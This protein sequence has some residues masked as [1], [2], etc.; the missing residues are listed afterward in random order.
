MWFQNCA[1]ALA[2]AALI[3]VVAP[4]RADSAHN[5]PIMIDHLASAISFTQLGQPTWKPTVQT[6]EQKRYTLAQDGRN[7]VY[8]KAYATFHAIGVQKTALS[9][10]E[11]SQS[12]AR[13]SRWPQMA[14]ACE[15]LL[16]NVDVDDF[17]DIGRLVNGAATCAN[18]ANNICHEEP[19]NGCESFGSIDQAF[20]IFISE[21][22]SAGFF[23]GKL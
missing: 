10:I 20:R 23:Q 18:Y 15:S 11:F 3:L 7:D 5:R 16:E 22:K 21:E 9:M 2:T 1:T 4:S 12:I 8:A 19:A 13:N 14:D 6:H 17:D